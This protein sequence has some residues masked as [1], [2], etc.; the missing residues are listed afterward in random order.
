MRSMGRGRR[1]LAKESFVSASAGRFPL[2]S[3]AD[4]I[5]IA[6]SRH[7]ANSGSQLLDA[8]GRQLYRE[9]IKGF[10]S[11]S[12][13]ASLVAADGHIFAT[14]ED[15]QVIVLKAGPTFEALHAN[16][17]G[18][19]VLSTPAIAANTFVIRGQEHLIAIRQK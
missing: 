16:P 11:I 1:P 12:F 13:V 4:S 17:A 9:R 14:S 15:G 3:F 6:A 7:A 19:S 2:R 8:T 10:G 5:A 18:E